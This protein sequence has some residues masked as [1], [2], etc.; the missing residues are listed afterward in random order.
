MVF[1][2]NTKHSF[3]IYFLR[4]AIAAERGNPKYKDDSLR[5]LTGA[6]QRKMRLA[7][8]G[9]KRLKLKFDTVISSPYVRARQTAEIVTQILPIKSKNIYFTKNLL[10]PASIKKLLKELRTLFPESESVLCVG[11]EPHLT[12]M[13]AELLGCTS[14]LAIDFKKGGLCCLILENAHATFNWL[15]TPAQ[16]V[17]MSKEKQ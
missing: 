8:L 4:H 10:P 1:L 6:G 13:I 16:L 12:E 2:A 11:H 5:P 9:M 14:P 3:Q 7:A 17:L 15:L